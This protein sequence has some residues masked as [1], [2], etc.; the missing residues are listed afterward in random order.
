MFVYVFTREERERGREREIEIERER[1]RI[2]ECSDVQLHVHIRACML[3][4]KTKAAAED[5]RSLRC[6]C[7]L[8]AGQRHR[9]RGSTHGNARIAKEEQVCVHMDGHVCMCAC[10]EVW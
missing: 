6:I 1:K 7:S 10:M 2:N 9:R 3:Q 4:S 8:H 5:R